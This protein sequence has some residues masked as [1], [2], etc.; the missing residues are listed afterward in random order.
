MLTLKVEKHEPNYKQVV[1][2]GAPEG[3]VLPIKLLIVELKEVKSI[4]YGGN[5][6]NAAY[7]T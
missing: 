3:Q 1:N 6:Y 4:H 7:I 5:I 2:S